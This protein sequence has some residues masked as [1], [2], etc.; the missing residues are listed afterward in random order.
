[1]TALSPEHVDLSFERIYLFLLDMNKLQQLP[2]VRITLFVDRAAI[3]NVNILG[4]GIE[5]VFQV[6]LDLCEVGNTSKPP[7]VKGCDLRKL[8]LSPVIF[9]CHR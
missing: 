2:S 6:V 3:S 8:I 5:L 1:M 7:S 4:G 9:C